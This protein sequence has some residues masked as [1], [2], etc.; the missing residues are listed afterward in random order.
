MGERAI[1]SSLISE[2]INLPD[3]TCEALWFGQPWSEESSV[4]NSTAI[5][6][7]AYLP[8][9]L[10]ETVSK[11]LSISMRYFKVSTPKLHITLSYDQATRA[12]EQPRFSATKHVRADVNH[13]N[14][15]TDPMN[16]KYRV[17]VKWLHP[18]E[19]FKA[20]SDVSIVVLNSFSQGSQKTLDLQSRRG[21]L[22]DLWLSR[23]NDLVSIKYIVC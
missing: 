5:F 23:G 20:R 9:K 8:L 1:E 15:A 19:E 4:S 14:R 2:S 11:E 16:V 6:T 7:S 22:K 17:D 13:V 21:L 12:I 18:D 10:G 3:T